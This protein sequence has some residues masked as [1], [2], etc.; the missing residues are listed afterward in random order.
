MC[1]L[2]AIFPTSKVAAQGSC[3]V[4]LFAGVQRRSGTLFSGDSGA[5]SSATLTTPYGVWMNPVSENLLISDKSNNRMRSVPISTKTISTFAGTGAGTANVAYVGPATAAG[6]VIAPHTVCGDTTGTLYLVE[7][8][9]GVVRKISSSG[10][11]SAFAGVS[12]VS[13][14][15]GLNGRATSAIL[16]NPIHCTV[17]SN[18]DVYIADY[19]NYRVEKVTVSNTV[20]TLF[21]GTGSSSPFQQSTVRTSANLFLPTNVFVD[22]VGGFYLAEYQ[23]RVWKS[24]AG[25]NII[26]TFAGELLSLF[27]AVKTYFCL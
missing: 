21:A 15:S 10:I 26:T 1:F 18:G 5:A 25:S 3:T 9:L 17:D 27:T 6:V 14:N 16:N 20:M 24:A 13:G 23:S 2:F 22:S 8:S 11:L 19:Y 12:G 7:Q 4:S